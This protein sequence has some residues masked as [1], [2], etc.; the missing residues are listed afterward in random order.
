MTTNH[1]VKTGLA[2]AKA[3]VPPQ[4]LSLYEGW[5]NKEIDISSGYNCFYLFALFLYLLEY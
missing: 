5:A 3:R 4:T 2:P 1:A